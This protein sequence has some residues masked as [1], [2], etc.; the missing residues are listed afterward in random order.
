MMAGPHPVIPAPQPVIPGTYPVSPAPPCHPERSEGSS[1]YSMLVNRHETAPST[2]KP[3][4][5]SP[6][7]YH[8]PHPPRHPNP[9]PCHPERSEGSSLGPT[10]IT[11]HTIDPG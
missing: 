6:T 9:P 3:R 1:P 8:P 7:L 5:P 10:P 2:A 11:H 4:H